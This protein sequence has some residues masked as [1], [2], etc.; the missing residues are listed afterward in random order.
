MLCRVLELKGRNPKVKSFVEDEL[1][2]IKESAEPT[3]R[4]SLPSED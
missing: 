3:H 2:E 1:T 4:V